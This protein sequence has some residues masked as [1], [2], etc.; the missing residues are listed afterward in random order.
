MRP[1][2]HVRCL[3]LLCRPCTSCTPF[4]DEGEMH[5]LDQHRLA[6]AIGQTAYKSDTKPQSNKAGNSASL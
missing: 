3:K 4:L 5:N 6:P 1:C 2:E